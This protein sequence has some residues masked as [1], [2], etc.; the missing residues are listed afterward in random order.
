MFFKYSYDVEIKQT[1]WNTGKFNSK[2][3]AGVI[4]N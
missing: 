2:N 1:G 3:V 4:S